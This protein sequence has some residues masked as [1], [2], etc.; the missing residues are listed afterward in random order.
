MLGDLAQ[1]RIPGDY[2]NAFVVGNRMRI[3]RIFTYDCSH[4]L[5]RAYLNEEIVWV[6]PHVTT[7]W[8]NLIFPI[9]QTFRMIL[10]DIHGKRFKINGKRA[11]CT[12]ALGFYEAKFPHMVLGYSDELRRLYNRER[13]KFLAL[14]YNEAKQNINCYDWRAEPSQNCCG[15]Q[16]SSDNPYET[17]TTYGNNRYHI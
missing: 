9:G 12:Q 5:T 8:I 16:K 13:P 14:R 6:Y 17:P 10:Y 11:L 2:T 15:E 3:G 7:H 1:A 4:F